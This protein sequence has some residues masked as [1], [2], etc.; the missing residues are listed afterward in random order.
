MDAVVEAFKTLSAAG[1]S[2]RL[3]EARKFHQY[4]ELQ[5]KA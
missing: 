3:D 2:L 5:H 1:F 4:H